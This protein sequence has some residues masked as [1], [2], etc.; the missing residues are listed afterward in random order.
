[1]TTTIVCPL[2]ACTMRNLCRSYC[3]KQEL[4]RNGYESRDGVLVKIEQPR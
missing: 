3:V 4:A 2:G 1:M